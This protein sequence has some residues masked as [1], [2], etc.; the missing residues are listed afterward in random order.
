MFWD[1]FWGDEV[2][3]IAPSLARE[4]FDTAVNMGVTRSVS[5]LQE[6]LNV[7]NRNQLLYHDLTVD[8]SFGPKSIEALQQYFSD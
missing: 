5:F 1:R 8:G 7:L 6:A 3:A 4:L 2:S